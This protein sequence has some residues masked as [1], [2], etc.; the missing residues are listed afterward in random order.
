MKT[1]KVCEHYYTSQ[2]TERTCCPIFTEIAH[3]TFDDVE[4]FEVPP[5]FSCLHFVHKK[6]IKHTVSVE[7]RYD[8]GEFLGFFV[9]HADTVYRLSSK[10]I[11]EA[12]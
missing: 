10:E 4:E 6:N 2:E 5:D 3:R 11:K 8:R 12:K 1:C 9:S 7:A